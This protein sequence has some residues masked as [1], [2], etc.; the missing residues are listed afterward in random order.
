MYFHSL[1][2]QF[3]V[4][5]IGLVCGFALWRGGRPEKLVAVAYLMAW[6]F[7][8]ISHAAHHWVGPQ[9]GVLVIDGLLLAWL[10][11]VALRSDRLWPL[12]AAGFH[13]VG[14]VTHLAMA[15]DP[16]VA[17]L[18][19]YRGLVIWSYLSLVP[20]ALGTWNVWRSATPQKASADIAPARR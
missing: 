16:S 20:L 15:V 8:P 9:W 4:L 17:P 14:V 2:Q 12:F 13:L 19:Y 11:T 7:T 18:P 1:P 5:A 10:I 3:W 6:L